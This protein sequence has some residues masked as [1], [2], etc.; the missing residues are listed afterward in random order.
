MSATATDDKRF[1]PAWEG[2][3]SYRLFAQS[4]KHSLRYVRY[5]AAEDFLASVLATSGGRRR[6]IPRGTL[7]WRARLGCDYEPA[8]SELGDVRAE[9][10]QERPYGREGMKPIP[11]WQTEGRAN[12]RGIPYLYMATTADTALAEVRPWV[13]S[14]ISIAQFAIRRQLTVIDCSI[15]HSADN[16]LAVF[17]NKSMTREEGMWIAIDRAYAT[18]VTRSDESGEYIPTQIIAEMFKR[19]G[20]DGIVFKS[21]LSKDCQSASKF[22]PLEG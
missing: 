6:M 21:L 5:T 10:D 3:E 14:E 19:E 4:V 13:G 12:P 2:W 20:F 1:G 17:T 11:N 16:L 9:W 22:D 18:P 15:H 8:C 7:Y